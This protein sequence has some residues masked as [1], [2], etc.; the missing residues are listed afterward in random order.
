MRH[1]KALCDKQP[2]ILLFIM[3]TMYN[4]YILLPLFICCDGYF[5]F[6]CFY[7]HTFFFVS[8]PRTKM[9]NHDNKLVFFH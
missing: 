3:L 2:E 7:L 1:Q 4:L 9:T 6:C 8:T 5:H